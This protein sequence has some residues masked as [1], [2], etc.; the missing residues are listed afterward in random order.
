MS[1]LH[2]RTFIP[3]AVPTERHNRLIGNGDFYNTICQKRT[4]LNFSQWSLHPKAFG[5][6]DSPVRWSSILSATSSHTDANASS[7]FFTKGSS[8]CSASFRYMAA[9]PRKESGQSCM[10]NT[11]P[12]SLEW[13]QSIVGLSLERRILEA[14]VGSQSADATKLRFSSDAPRC[15]IPDRR[16]GNISRGL[17]RRCPCAGVA[18]SAAP[19]TALEISD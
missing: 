13:S 2:L 10:P 18:P 9:W 12:L 8:V 3:P 17:Q 5:A 15:G 7:S 6:T 16:R 14:D 19:I 11:V 4:S 1:D